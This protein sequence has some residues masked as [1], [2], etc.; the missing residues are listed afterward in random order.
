MAKFE[1]LVSAKLSNDSVKNIQQ[2]LDSVSSSVSKTASDAAKGSQGIADIIGKFSKWQLVGDAIHGVKDGM[3]D[4]VN[5]V[6]ELD[7]SLVEFNKVTD[8]TPGQLEQITSK[9]YEL[10]EQLSR[11]G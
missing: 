7:A 5:Q 2:Q 8:V 11:T 1:V 10:G 3:S 6:F 4:M 9:A